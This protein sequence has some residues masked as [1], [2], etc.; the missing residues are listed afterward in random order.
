MTSDH[1]GRHQVLPSLM[2]GRGV[3]RPLPHRKVPVG[4]PSIRGG[5]DVLGLPGQGLKKSCKALMETVFGHLFRVEPAA[6]KKV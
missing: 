5:R 6:L 3:Q 2:S 4:L 1:R